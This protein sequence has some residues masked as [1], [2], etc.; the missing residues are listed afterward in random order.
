VLWLN[1]VMLAVFA[2]VYLM[3]AHLLLRKQE[4]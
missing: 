2:V 4:A 3:A 1:V